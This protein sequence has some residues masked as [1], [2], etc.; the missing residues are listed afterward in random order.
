MYHGTIKNVCIGCRKTG[1]RM[2]NFTPK[3]PQCQKDMLPLMPY[4]VI[5]KKKDKDSWEKLITKCQIRL[6]SD[7]DRRN[8]VIQQIK[9]IESNKPQDEI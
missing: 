3:C 5:P 6:I 7:E 8:D 4:A 2:I 1:P 9:K